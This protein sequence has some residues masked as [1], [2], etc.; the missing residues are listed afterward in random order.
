MREGSRERVREMEEEIRAEFRKS[1]FSLDGEEE[2]LEKCK[3]Y[4]F[5]FAMHIDLDK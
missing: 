2:I 5:H 3:T 1:G 4:V